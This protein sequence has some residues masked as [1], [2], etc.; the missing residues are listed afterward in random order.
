LRPSG[1]NALLVEAMSADI[2]LTTSK[3]KQI[4]LPF[5]RPQLG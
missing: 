5:A 4:V 1:A 2:F 3:Q